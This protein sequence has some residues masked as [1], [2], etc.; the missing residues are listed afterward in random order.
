MFVNVIVPPLLL[1]IAATTGKMAYTQ[2]RYALPMTIPYLTLAFCGLSE[3][4]RR[5]IYRCLVAFALF[6]CAIFPFYPSLWNQSWTE[7]LG[8]I[9]KI[10]QP[11]DII[12]INPPYTSYSFAMAYDP[13]NISFTFSDDYVA[14]M[15]QKPSQD[16]LPAFILDASMLDDSLLRDLRGYRIILIMCQERTSPTSAKVLYWFD[17][18]YDLVDEHHFYSTRTW[19][20]INTYVI[21]PKPELVKLQRKGG[22]I[23][24]TAK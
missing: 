12:A 14:G 10:K 5:Q 23:R 11:N 9:D 18:Y 17:R 16:K 6:I 8:Y 13:E 20:N 19:A 7:T 4:S 15:F 1:T 22:A 2:T 3:T 21:A 24:A